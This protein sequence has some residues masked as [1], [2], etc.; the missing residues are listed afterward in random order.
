VVGEVPEP[1]AV[2]AQGFEAAFGAGD[3]SDSCVADPRCARVVP[4]CASK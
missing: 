2:A 1:N 4:G 3:A